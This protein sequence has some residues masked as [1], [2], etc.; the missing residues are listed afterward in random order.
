MINLRPI[1]SFVPHLL[2]STPPRMATII[3]STAAR[4]SQNATYLS[5]FVGL[6][7]KYNIHSNCTALLI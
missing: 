4:T 6:I 1:L 5:T 2:C 3:Q 7:A